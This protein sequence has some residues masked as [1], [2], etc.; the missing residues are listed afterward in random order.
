V[1]HAALDDRD[2][3]RL[4]E[5]LAKGGVAVFPADTVYG[6]G[7]DPERRTAVERLYQLKGR[8]AD[9]SAA[10]M[11]FALAPALLALPELNGSERAAITALLPGP[12]T[13]L[14]PNRNRRFPLACGPDP[15]TLGLRVPLLGRALAAL[16][17]VPGPMLQSSANL[18]GKAE[19]RR[20]ADVP[21]SI[22]D[23]ADLAL[24]GGELPGVASTVVDLCQYERSGEWSV[25]R[26]GAMAIEAV[27]RALT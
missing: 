13:L 14:L 10:V 16:G 9:R 12:V 2:A 18:T 27:E 20:L 11:F 23:G 25:V 15:R 1:T 17:A 7:C 19:A 3:T 4:Q 26:R 24:D 8:R 22:L 5:C 6:L 21:P